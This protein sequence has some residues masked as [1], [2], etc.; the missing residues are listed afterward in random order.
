MLRLPFFNGNK[1]REG[2]FFKILFAINRGV[3]W[4]IALFKS[5]SVSG[6]NFEKFIFK[7]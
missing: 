1:E 3:F 6:L 4:V 7:G 2:F 5:P